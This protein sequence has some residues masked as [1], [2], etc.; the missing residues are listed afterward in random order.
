MRFSFLTSLSAVAL[1]GSQLYS[2]SAQQCTYIDTEGLRLSVSDTATAMFQDFEVGCGDNCKI[3]VTPFQTVSVRRFTD[4]SQ[5]STSVNFVDQYSSTCQESSSTICYLNSTQTINVAANQILGTP[6]GESV[7]IDIE[8]PVC[9][10]ESCAESQFED[11][12]VNDRQCQLATAAGE[13]CVVVASATCPENRVTTGDDFMCASDNPGPFTQLQLTKNALYTLMDTQCADA[14]ANGSNRFCDVTTI[15]SV[16]TQKNSYTNFIETSSSFVSYQ[17]DCAF[18]GGS[19]CAL[20]F[21]LKITPFS[22]TISVVSFE[23]DYT[24]YPI[25]IPKGCTDNDSLATEYMIGDLAGTVSAIS[26]CDPN[27]GSC[28]TSVSNMMCFPDPVKEIETP[29]AEVED[30]STSVDK[31]EDEEANV[32]D[33]EESKEVEESSSVK[34]K[35]SSKLFIF[36][37]A[38]G[39]FA[40]QQ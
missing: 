20:T 34:M 36:A 25:C 22:D 31:E 19:V 2:I 32:N 18:S 33:V 24:D 30:S 35:S 16:S 15:P 10:P 3:S 12:N 5:L 13:S 8:K 9:Y 23:Y 38:I 1:F 17:E 27:V 29:I 4:F 21:N 6:V 37:A 11:L 7:V 14:S 26:L 39:T 40:V 28:E